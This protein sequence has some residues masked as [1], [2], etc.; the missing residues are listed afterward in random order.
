MKVERS[1]ISGL[2]L[3]VFFRSLTAMQASG[4]PLLKSFEALSESVENPLLKWISHQTSEHLSQGHPLSQCLTNYP[5]LFTLFH[6]HLIKVGEQ[7][8]NLSEVLGFIATF[9]E[10]RERLVQKVR[11]ALVYPTLVGLVA[12]LGLVFVLPYVLSGIFDVIRDLGAE[13]PLL[14][15][16]VMG[17]SS[18]LSS[19]LGWLGIPLTCA[20]L[21][22]PLKGKC[23][24]ASFRPHLLKVPGLGN[25]V[26][27]TSSARFANALGLSLKS[28]LNVQRSLALAAKASGDPL[29]IQEVPCIS[30]AVEEGSSL[31]ESIDSIGFFTPLFV[32]IVK[33]G[34]EVGRTDQMLEWLSESLEKD[35]EQDLVTYASLLEPLMLLT[36]GLIVGVIV[37]ATAMPMLNIVQNLG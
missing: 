8:G 36:V 6:I 28:G 20:L 25:C 1:K 3:V 10:S 27:S 33:S 37:L 18:V 16:M 24:S 30:K 34:E 9:E 5:K 31:S 15:K 23:L 21:Y 4:V 22:S 26:R 7:T 14:T 12:L 2:E 29:L 13:P 11:S 19:P 17:A 35:L 32:E